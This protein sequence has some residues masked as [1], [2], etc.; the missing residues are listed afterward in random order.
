MGLLPYYRGM[1]VAEWACFQ[2]DQ[3]GC[4]VHLID[5]GIDTGGTL[6]VQE[7]CTDGVT[8][9]AALR[10]RVD[11]AQIALLGKIV[12]YII[13]TGTLPSTWPNRAADGVQFFRMHEELTVILERELTIS[14]GGRSPEPRE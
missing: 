5:A 12:R 10:K 2:G 13:E 8:S 14:G 7:V 3:V 1:N 9:I 11:D 4:T 6:C